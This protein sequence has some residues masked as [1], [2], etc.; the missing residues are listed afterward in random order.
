LDSLDA[1]S[2][3][4]TLKQDPNLLF[5]AQLRKIPHIHFQLELVL[6]HFSR[7]LRVY[8]V[9]DEYVLAID[10]KDG[11]VDRLLFFVFVGILQEGKPFVALVL[12][13]SRYAHYLYL[14]KRPEIF[15]QVFFSGQNRN[16]SYEYALSWVKVFESRLRLDAAN[17]RIDLATL[18]FVFRAIFIR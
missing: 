14:T 6:S 16:P 18:E 7:L 10:V 8:E 3:N 17:L 9:F 4:Q 5:S 11:C 2:S 12:L 15:G 13:E 1:F